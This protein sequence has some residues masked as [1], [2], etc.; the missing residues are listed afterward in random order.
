MPADGQNIQFLLGRDILSRALCIY[1]G[2][3]GSFSLV[4]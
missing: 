2:P 1:N 3:H 4:F